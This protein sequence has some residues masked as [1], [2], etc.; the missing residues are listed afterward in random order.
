MSR[1]YKRSDRITVKIN[2]VTLKLAPL[3]IDEK[4]EIQQAM[5]NGR[6]KADLKEVTR[7]TALSLKYSIKGISGLLDSDDN[8]YKLQFDDKGYLT[9]DCVSDLLN[10]EFQDKIVMICCT[11]PGGVPAQFTDT[12]GNKIEGVEI[13]KDGNPAKNS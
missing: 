4:T 9:D 1:I 10:L 6:A 11:L 2:D 3:S 5:L 8:E 12:K 13:L 7:G